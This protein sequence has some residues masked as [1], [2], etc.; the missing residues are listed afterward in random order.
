MAVDTGDVSRAGALQAFALAEQCDAA[1][2]LLHVAESSDD[3][4]LLA[5]D[6]DPRELTTELLED[7]AAEAPAAVPVETEVREGTA[8][9]T[10][11]R[12]AE[13]RAADVIVAGRRSRSGVSRWLLGSVTDEVL[14]NSDRPV[15]IVPPGPPTR[16]FD[17]I[18]LPTDGSERAERAAGAVGH[19]AGADEAIVHVVTVVD[20]QSAA[21][22]FDAGGVT[23]EFVDRLESDGQAHVDSMVDRL[24][25]EDEELPVETAV[26]RGRPHEQLAEHATEHDVG[27]IVMG[28]HGRSGF[29]RGVYG[30]VTERVLRSVDVPVLVVTH[31]E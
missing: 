18:L 31:G 23:P 5:E 14:A 27:V 13:D 19:L 25:G 20:V 24:E 6:G 28:A 26:R 17:R 16:G 29:R 11:L 9:E 30:S 2:T 21:G 4:P 7:I 8:A 15:L 22:P 3:S 10:I 12:V 1:V